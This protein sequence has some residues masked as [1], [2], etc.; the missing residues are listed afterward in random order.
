VIVG[1]LPKTVLLRAAG[2][3]MDSLVRGTLDLAA[4]PTIS[5][6]RSGSETRYASGDD[7]GSEDNRARIVAEGIRVGAFPLPEGSRDAALLL[8]LEP[9]GYTAVVSNADGRPGV[10]LLEIYEVPP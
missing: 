2:P 1:E 10:V 8:A 9:G 5:L 3:A 7:H 4:D 6:Y